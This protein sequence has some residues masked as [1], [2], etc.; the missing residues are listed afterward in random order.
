V[1]TDDN[2][3]QLLLSD[4]V[5]MKLR[6]FWLIIVAIAFLLIAIPV[7]GSLTQDS[8]QL[9]AQQL[10]LNCNSPQTTSEINQCASQEVQAADRKLNQVYQQLKPKLRRNQQ[11]R[12]TNA[13]L[14]WIKFRDEA[15]NYEKGQ[16]EGGTLAS[17]TYS[18]CIARVT[19]QRLSDLEEYLEQAQL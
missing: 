11:Q 15:C 5:L 8:P 7:Q 10:K 19:R 18:Y 14:A 1:K 17:S 2:F 6:N 13:Q 9:F 12:I 4:L 3:Y 16:F